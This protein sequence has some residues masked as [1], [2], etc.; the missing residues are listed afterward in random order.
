MTTITKKSKS[1]REIEGLLYEAEK[2]VK[3]VKAPQDDYKAMTDDANRHRIITKFS[4]EKLVG[5]ITIG[6]WCTQE[7][8]KSLNS[9][10]AAP[11]TVIQVETW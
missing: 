2:T 1:D 8:L 6:P 11:H 10:L 7:T 3:K 9:S 4:L 5:K